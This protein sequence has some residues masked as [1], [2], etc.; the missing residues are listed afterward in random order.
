MCVYSNVL[1]HYIPLIPEPFTPPTPIPSI[2]GGGVSTIGGQWPWMPQ[3]DPA[4]LR[5]ILDEFKEALA[6]A[7]T[8][9]RL[10]GHPDCED[11]EKVKLVARVAELED[12]LAA[13]EREAKPILVRTGGRVTSINEDG[14]AGIFLYRHDVS[15]TFKVPDGTI[16]AWAARIGDFVSF[17]IEDGKL[18]GAAE[19]PSEGGSK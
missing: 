16:K 5:K 11:P 2:G 15:F 12:L 17:T 1:D 8:V 14:Y 4:E 10:V 6:A 7:K 13:K 3:I 19:L 9:D 18:D